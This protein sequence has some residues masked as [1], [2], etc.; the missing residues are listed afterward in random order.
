MWKV[1]LDGQYDKNFARKVDQIT[2]FFQASNS[3]IFGV[4]IRNI[5]VYEDIIEL[6]SLSP[7]KWAFFCMENITTVGV[8]TV[9]VVKFL[10]LFREKKF[11]EIFWGCLLYYI[12]KDKEIPVSPKDCFKSITQD[13]IKEVV[14][15][16]PIIEFEFTQDGL[17]TDDERAKAM[18]TVL[19]LTEV[20]LEAPS[21]CHHLPS[22][23]RKSHCGECKSTNQTSLEI[24]RKAAEAAIRMAEKNV[25][26]QNAIDLKGL[27]V[28]MASSSTSSKDTMQEGEVNI[29]LGVEGV[30]ELSG[31]KKAKF[32]QNE[33]DALK[34]IFKTG[35]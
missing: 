2:T 18:S 4:I 32:E 26:T 10:E 16:V 5:K 20:V 31:A 28:L 1:F 22:L 17:K 19:E 21:D 23:T 11:Q 14:D 25:D 15:T 33:S 35:N 3:N 29:G 24:R 30:A 27:N 13:D 8:F 34:N 6:S 9:D 12:M 7:D